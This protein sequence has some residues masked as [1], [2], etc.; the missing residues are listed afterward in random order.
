LEI[1]KEFGS[2]VRDIQI[3]PILCSLCSFAATP[4]SHLSVVDSSKFRDAILCALGALCAS[5]RSDFFNLIGFKTR[6]P[7]AE[8]QRAQRNPSARCGQLC[9]CR[10]FAK[11]AR[12][13]HTPPA[14]SWNDFDTLLV[15]RTW[16]HH[17]PVSPLK[18]TSELSG[19][20]VEINNLRGNCLPAL[21]HENRSVSEFQPLGCRF[22]ISQVLKEQAPDALLTRVL[23]HE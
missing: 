23:Y 15:W 20:I 9:A 18:N 19:I 5:L 4:N 14:D 22:P 12:A 6:K 7:P 2:W 1:R 8:E 11:L 21:Y 10:G 3:W 16:L 13:G 17:G